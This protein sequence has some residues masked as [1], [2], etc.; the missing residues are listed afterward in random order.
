MMKT[1][2]LI[3]LAIG[4]TQWLAFVG[5]SAMA[6]AKAPKKGLRT[7][8]RNLLVSTVAFLAMWLGALDVTGAWGPKSPAAVTEAGMAAAK[9][10]ASCATIAVGMRDAEVQTKMGRP[11]EVRADEETR[12]PGAETWVYRG[13]RCAVHLFE[14][15]VEFV[16]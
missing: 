16:D 13:A 11:D 5:I 4:V 10:G 1:L 3:V 8:D 15:K 12:G 9:P 6:K 7:V 2:P 14:R